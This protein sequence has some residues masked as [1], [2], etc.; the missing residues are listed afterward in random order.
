[1]SSVSFWLSRAR[2]A[3]R[4]SPRDLAIR[5]GAELRGE[6][7]RLQVA[8]RRRFDDESLLRATGAASIDALWAELSRRPYLA[9]VERVDP[10]RMRS[11]C[12]GEAERVDDAATRVGERIVDLLGSGP[13]R[14]GRPVDWLVDFKT[15]TR[16]GLGY[17]RRIAYTSLGRP[18]D[19]KVPW[20]LSRLQW[21]LPAGQAFLLTGDERHAAAVRELLEEWIAA[22]PYGWSVNWAVTMEVALRI[23]SWTWL[24]HVFH[25]STAWAETS[26]RSRFLRALYLHCE[27]TERNL[28]R[29]EVNGNHYAADA[30]GLTVGG[31]F[32]GEGGNARRWSEAGWSILQGELPRQV[33]PDGV[34]FEASTAYHRLVTELFFLP[35]LHRTRLGLPVADAYRDRIAAM[36]RFAV[37]YTRSDGTSPL[38]GDADDGRTLPLGGQALGDHR[39]LGGLVGTAWGIEDL[40]ASFSGPRSEIAWVLGLDAAA[41]LPADGAPI[42]SRAFPD[43]GYY[44]M[45]GPRDHVFVDAGPVGFAGRG[46]HGHNDCLSFEAWLD[47]VLILVD[48][49][50]YVYTADY[51][52]R[53]WFR[54][55]A[56]HNTPLV[57]GEEQNRFVRPEYLWLLR[58]DAAPAVSLWRPGPPAMLRASHAGYERLRSQVTP[59][60]TIALDP[61]C[62]LL[63]VRDEFAGTGEHD[64]T[65]PLHFVPG[66]TIEAWTAGL[67]SVRVGDRRFRVSWSDPSAWT[68]S[69]RPGLVSPSYGV[70]DPAPVLVFQ[71]HGALRRLLV[72]IAPD[73][74]PDHLARANALLEASA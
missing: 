7:E 40:R 14:L 67:S 33:H 5:A 23:I 61:D 51:V 48:S 72:T 8:R 60:R 17:G 2:A 43:G 41:A 44:V 57:D 42:P 19:V 58:D 22:D 20:E 34:D 47:G 1:M 36:A 25:A 69:E 70:A 30:A 71:R 28:E 10:T 31:L 27:Y 56:A 73:E 59:V 39:Y 53:N 37:A 24:F 12:P 11:V 65:V 54:A 52:A 62:H 29:A 55:T 68:V 38:V 50:A 13:V 74:G 6:L 9:A 4:R 15:G 49:G 3:T 16:W 32:F 64:V 18:S 35:A 45:R 26:F 46:G 21:A 66:A 63:A